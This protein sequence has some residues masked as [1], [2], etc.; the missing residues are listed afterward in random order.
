MYWSIIDVDR[1]KLLKNITETISIQNYYM[2]GGTALSLQL[3]LRESYDFV[4]CVPEYFYN[5]Q[6]LQELQSIRRIRS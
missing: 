5:E 6:L 2:I 4:F 1:R 3:G